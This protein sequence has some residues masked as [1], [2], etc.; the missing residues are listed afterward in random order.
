IN[1]DQVKEILDE[2]QED[3]DYGLSR[4]T[5]NARLY[6]LFMG[7]LRSKQMPKNE[8]EKSVKLI[9]EFREKLGWKPYELKRPIE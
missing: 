7:V 2:L 4:A 9:N 5:I 1:S 6:A 8:K 3:L